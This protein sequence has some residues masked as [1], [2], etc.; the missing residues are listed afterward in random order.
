MS[1]PPEREPAKRAAQR[2]LWRALEAIESHRPLP[3][4]KPPLDPEAWKQ[5]LALK[6]EALAYIETFRPWW[7]TR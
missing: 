2:E 3:K 5:Q 7:M 4:P 6:A 1:R